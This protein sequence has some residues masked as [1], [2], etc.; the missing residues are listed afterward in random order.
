MLFAINSSYFSLSMNH[1]IVVKIDIFRGCHDRYKSS[2]FQ[3]HISHLVMCITCIRDDVK[4]L[5]NSQ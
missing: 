4:R 2:L 3:Y 5:L 1:N